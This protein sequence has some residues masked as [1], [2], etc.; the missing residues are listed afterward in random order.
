MENPAHYRSRIA[1]YAEEENRQ[2]CAELDFLGKK[3]CFGECIIEFQR[4]EDCLSICISAMIGRS[5]KVGDIVTTEMS[6]RAQVAVYGSLFLHHMRGKSLPPDVVELIKR[7]H[8]A[9][10]ERNTLVHSLWDASEAKPNSIRRNK[11]GI[12]KHVFSVTEEH[13]TP[14]ELDDLS[15][16]FEGIATDLLALQCDHLPEK[17]APRY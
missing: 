17:Y 8:W 15:R 14:D 10:Q 16:T 1:C 4:I 11:K 9:E 5:R 13:R 2:A 3:A 6:F 12:R 7:L